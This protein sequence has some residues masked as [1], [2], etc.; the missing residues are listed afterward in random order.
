[1]NECLQGMRDGHRKG[2]MLLWNVVVAGYFAPWTGLARA[3]IWLLCVMSA[4]QNQAMAEATRRY[5]QKIASRKR[6]I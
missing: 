1:V 2:A 5:D 6:N 3:I 4:W